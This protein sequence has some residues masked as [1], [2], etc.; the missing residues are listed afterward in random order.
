MSREPP[1]P[2]RALAPALPPP[3]PQGASQPRKQGRVAAQAWS[4]MPQSGLP[5][6]QVSS[7]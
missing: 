7:G 5:P 4:H 2:P 1:Q 3:A 6:A